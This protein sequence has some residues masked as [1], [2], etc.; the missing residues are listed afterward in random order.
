MNSYDVQ[1]HGTTDQSTG[2]RKIP[3]VAPSLQVIALKHAE[4]GPNGTNNDS[5]GGHIKRP[6]S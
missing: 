2:Q 1:D 3:W 5:F 6:R 4:H